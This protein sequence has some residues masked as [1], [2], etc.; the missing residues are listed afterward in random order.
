MHETFKSMN[1]I[2]AGVKSVNILWMLDTNQECLVHSLERP[3]YG[4]NTCYGKG[5]G[6][7]WR[8]GPSLNPDHLN[9]V[10]LKG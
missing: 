7:L 4:L 3:K 1:Y 10:P 9:P 5:G 6:A 8:V 2:S